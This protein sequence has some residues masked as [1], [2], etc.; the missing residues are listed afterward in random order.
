MITR[1]IDISGDVWRTPLLLRVIY[2]LLGIGNFSAKFFVDIW[3]PETNESDVRIYI[4]IHRKF[5]EDIS[6][7]ESDILATVQDACI[8]HDIPEVDLIAPKIT[9]SI[10]HALASAMLDDLFFECGMFIEKYYSY[11]V[12]DDGKLIFKRR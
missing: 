12:T 1:N 3:N 5:P 2:R 9:Y 10:T 8:I 7:V 6:E 11:S 4:K